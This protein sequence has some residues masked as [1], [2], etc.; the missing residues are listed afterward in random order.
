MRARGLQMVIRCG[1]VAAMLAMSAL[2]AP[3]QDQLELH[4]GPKDSTGFAGLTALETLSDQCGVPVSV[5][6]SSGDTVSLAAL[7]DSAGD[8]LAVV[9]G[10]VLEYLRS[11]QGQDPAIARAI[12]GVELV[13]PLFPLTVHLLARDGIADV[14]GLNGAR[15]NLGS[16]D[17]GTFLTATLVL[18]TLGLTPAERLTMPSADAVVALQDGVLDAVFVVDAAP[19]ELVAGIAGGVR[20]L[21]LTDPLLADFYRPMDIPGGSYAFSAQPVTSIAVP[22]FMVA[23]TKGMVLGG[24]SCA[25]LRKFSSLIMQERDRL[26]AESGTFWAAM[27]PGASLFDWTSTPCGI[28]SFDFDAPRICK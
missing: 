2:A 14:N 12:E 8:R 4:A 19:S 16:M 1:L 25:A 20:I 18:E 28:A 17:E 11:Y 21:P 26:A 24:P 13:S 3:A 6:A 15:V 9:Q 27:E 22:T 23:R 7:G 5:H 10:D